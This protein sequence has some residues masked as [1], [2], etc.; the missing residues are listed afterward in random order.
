LA[1]VEAKTDYSSASDGLQQAKEYAEILG[2]KFAYSTNGAEIVEFDYLTGQETPLT[3][4]PT[5]S[6]LWSRLLLS[7]NR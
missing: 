4:F 1:V 6:Q 3:E 2:L 5:P 7:G